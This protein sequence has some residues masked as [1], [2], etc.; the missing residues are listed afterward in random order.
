MRTLVISDLHLGSRSAHDVLRRPAAR[1]ALFAALEDVE[2]LVLLGDTVEL[3][4]GR[5]RQAMKVAIPILSELGAALGRDREVVVVAG[6]HDHLLVRP[7]LRTQRIQTRNL[8]L[9]ARVPRA[10]SPNLKAVAAALKPARVSVRYPGVWLDDRVWATHGH[11][12]DRHLLPEGSTGFLLGRVPEGRATAADYERAAGPSAAAMQ[13]LL[14][15]SLPKMFGEPL[16]RA[17]GMARRAGIAAL[18][19]AAALLGAGTLAPFSASA[20]GYQFR[21]AGL[22]AMAEVSTRLRV[23][24]DHVIFGHLHRSGPRFGDYLPEWTPRE[25]HTLVNSGCW[26]YEPLLLAGAH[27]PHPYWPGGAVIVEGDGSRPKAV[28]LLDSVDA[29]DLV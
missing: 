4:E 16:D 19:L 15:A 7:W 11:Y 28:G 2:R 26:V 25:G 24:A 20:L 3:L 17:A 13:G 21:R 27:P 12:L 29:S 9:A 1:E 6:N 5:P 10:S 22:P 8:G 18:P 14:A 23:R